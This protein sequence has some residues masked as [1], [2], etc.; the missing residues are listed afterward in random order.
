MDRLKSHKVPIS[1]L[2]SLYARTR[3]SKKGYPVFR[4][5]LAIAQRM[6]LTIQPSMTSIL[7]KPIKDADATFRM[8]GSGSTA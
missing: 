6:N 8:A 5:R 2:R 4:V 7:G 1:P 3:S